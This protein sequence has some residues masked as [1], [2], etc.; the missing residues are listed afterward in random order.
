MRAT[1]LPLP[2][3]DLGRL[4]ERVKRLA[5]ERPAVY[6]MVDPTGR[7]LYVGKAR[8]LRT[9]LLSY[10]RARYPDD[11][12]ARIIHAAADVQWDYAPSEF[13]ALL[14]EIRAIKRFRPPLNVA[15]NRKRQAVFVTVLGG[16]APRLAASRWPSPARGEERVY[17]PFVSPRRVREGIRALNDLL[18]LRDCPPRMPM[19]FADQG[20]LFAEPRQAACLRHDI[21]QC[22]GPCAGL[23]TLERYGAAAAAAVA[24]LEA[25]SVRP[26][27]RVIDAM[28]RS[29]AEAEYEAAT[30]W[31][32]K[33]EALE[34]LL[35]A[36]VRARAAVELLTFVYRDP[37]THGDDRAYLIRRGLVRASFPYPTTPIEREAFQA[38]V[39]EELAREV[40]EDAVLP[41]EGVDEM[42]VVMAW[43][44][45]HPEA[46]RRTRP[47]EEWL[48]VAS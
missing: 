19:V 8:R 40:P 21:G 44:R 3:T 16:P 38:A 13:A 30:R 18:G 4:R 27:D 33:F 5:E 17:G 26:L 6:R 32:E 48:P 41:V 43:F 22:L 47:L 7:V 9:R 11:K 24:F 12:A 2:T 31:R 25:R 20:D 14:G 29:A 23:V 42:L 34:W 28:Q 1:L 46:L 15:G 39:A 35:S 36:T 37:G 45:R 10:F